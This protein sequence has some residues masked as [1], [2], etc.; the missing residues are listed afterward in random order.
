M[1]WTYR[2][3][4]PGLLALLV[5]SLQQVQGRLQEKLRVGR[6]PQ[7]SLLLLPIESFRVQ[8]SIIWTKTKTI[9]FVSVDSKQKIK[10][11]QVWPW[12]KNYWLTLLKK[13]KKLLTGQLIYYNRIIIKHSFI[14]YAIIGLLKF[15]TF[16]HILLVIS[17]PVTLQM[18]PK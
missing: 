14:R 15:L 17:R 7:P 13:K 8:R 6:K 5:T 9:S 11:Q 18:T 12:L 10:R 4:G 2:L 3:E 1:D 16:K